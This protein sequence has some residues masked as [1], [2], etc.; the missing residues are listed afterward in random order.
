MFNE[1]TVNYNRVYLK[2]ILVL[3]KAKK[4]CDQVQIRANET[5]WEYDGH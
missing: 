3:F 2:N 5:S 1:S 4:T